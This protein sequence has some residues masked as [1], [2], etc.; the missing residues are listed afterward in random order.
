MAVWGSPLQLEEADAA[1]KAALEDKLTDKH[2]TIKETWWEVK[3]G[4][5][6]KIAK[7]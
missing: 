3:I 5:A 2:A 6:G 4:N 1:I 7:L